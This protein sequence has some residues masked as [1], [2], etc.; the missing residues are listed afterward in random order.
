MLIWLTSGVDLG[1][2]SAGGIGGRA[3]QVSPKGCGLAIAGGGDLP[4]ETIGAVSC[5]P[6]AA[7]AGQFKIIS[8]GVCLPLAGGDFVLLEGAQ[9]SPGP[10][11][12][13]LTHKAERGPSLGIE[14]ELLASLGRVPRCQCLSAT[15][16][17]SWCFGD[18][19]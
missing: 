10:K 13:V 19:G 7:E 17:V 14:T 18:R 8:F 3:V 9:R 5:V 16:G 2:P 15:D 12:V 1:S 6:D 4:L 11:S